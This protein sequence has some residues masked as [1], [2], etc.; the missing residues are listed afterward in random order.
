MH[1]SDIVARLLHLAV[2][3]TVL[4][5]VRGLLLDEGIDLR[6]LLDRYFVPKMPH[7]LDE[8]GFALGKGKRQAVVKRRGD[9]IAAVPPSFCAPAASE[10][11]IAWLDGQVRRATRGVVHGWLARS[12]T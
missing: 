12:E 2:Q 10:H 9:R 3:M 11:H 4:A 6:L 5:A 1:G 7:A 8:K